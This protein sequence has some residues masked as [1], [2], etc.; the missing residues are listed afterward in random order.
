MIYSLG[1]RA[2][3]VYVTLHERILSGDL[4]PGTK[5]PSHT[6]LATEFGVAPLTVRQVLA[7]L[8]QEGLVSREQGRGT[9]VRTGASPAVL[10]VED[11]VSMRALLRVHITLAGYRAIE[12][13]TPEEGIE[14]METDPAI[15]LVLSDVRVPSKEA[16][17]AFIRSV[18]H[19]WPEIPLAAVTGFP[20]DLA[21]LHG[22]PECPV[23]ILPKPF[24]TRQI[25]EALRLALRPSLSDGR[26]SAVSRE[27]GD[28]AE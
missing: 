13:P 18:R 23:L 10:V 16:G 4:M 15:A 2:H 21:E 25:E 14:V 22:K 27:G 5:L 7:H 17:I 3:R 20:D 11:D 8:E 24:W 1:P 12:V 6:E 26:R 28:A 19:R 9:F